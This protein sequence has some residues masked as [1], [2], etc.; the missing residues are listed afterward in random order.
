MI[1]ADNTADNAVTII[2]TH[3]AAARTNNNITHQQTTNTQQKGI[4]NT[5]DEGTIGSMVS[6]EPTSPSLRL[7]APRAITTFDAGNQ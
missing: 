7:N 3:A 4:I 6:A 5:H 2:A 1:D